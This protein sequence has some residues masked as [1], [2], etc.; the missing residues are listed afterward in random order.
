MATTEKNYGVIPDRLAWELPLVSEAT[1]ELTPF[2]VFTA[3]TPPEAEHPQ[4]VRPLARTPDLALYVRAFRDGGGEN[5]LHSHP[6][7][8]IWLVLEGQATFFDKEGRVL[9]ELQPHQGVLVP[10]LAS[11]RFVC[12]G[13]TLMARFAA[14]SSA[15]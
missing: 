6:D 2:Q 3:G 14:A 5:G 9:G 11:Y 1:S 8:A 4:R 10:A 15:R 12:R 13:D 7:D